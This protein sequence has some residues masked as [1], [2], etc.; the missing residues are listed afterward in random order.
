MEP[1]VK[2]LFFGLLAGLLLFFVATPSF[3]QE[4]FS[5]KDNYNKAEYRIPMRDGTL[6]YTIVYSP[7]DTSVK[8]PILLWR[9]PYSCGPYGPGKYRWL[10]EELAKE[11]FIFVY[12]DVRGRFMSE[13]KFVNMRPYIENKTSNK[14]VDESSDAYDTEEWLVK[15]VKDNNG[16]IGIFGISYPGFYAAMACIDANPALKAASP[17]APISNW[18][19]DDDFHRHGAFVLPMFFNFYQ[20]F[21]VKRDSLIKNWPKRM[22]YASPDAYDFFMGLEPLSNIDKKYFHGQIAFWETFKKHPNYDAYWQSRNTLPHFKKVKPAVMTVG[23]WY[24]SEDFYGTIH[25][26]ETIRKNNPEGKDYLV[27]GPWPHGW[28]ARGNDDHLGDLSFGSAT[29]EYYRQDIQLP[30]FNYYLKGKGSFNQSEARMFNTGTLEWSSFDQWPPKADQK[31][32]LVLSSDHQLLLNHAK[33]GVSG[34]DE[35]VSDP[36]KPVPYTEKEIDSRQMYYH[37]WLNADQRYASTRPDVLVYTSKTLDKDITLAGPLLADLY[38]STTG[39]DADWVV[40]IID[41]YPD[42]AA[43]PNP[44]PTHVKMGGYQALVRGD[45]LRGKYR[46][47]YE[48]PE[49]FVPGKVT[50]IKLPL[51]DVY[52]TFKKGHKI[53]IQIQSSW[54]P[55]FDINPQTFTN[56]YTATK[57]DFIKATQKV[58]FSK[59]YPSRI[60][61]DVLK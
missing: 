37:G 22:S 33:A 40:K 39:T 34:Y 48:H 60:E 12:Q 46:N 49:P 1:K 59:E 3:A 42:S 29:G 58:Y 21:G 55:F 25:T 6:L 47:S 23:G 24:D 11:K 53:M 31:E 19:I 8:Y 4:P 61:V 13:G 5:V 20:T 14:Q 54:F 36:W 35:Y 10:P 18:F 2:R 43:D 52:H 45:I 56:I 51:Q 41:V 27:I 50:E 16:K 17:Q 30:F 57:K 9:T 28:W 26:F 15:N 32:N 38:V 44:N 7:K